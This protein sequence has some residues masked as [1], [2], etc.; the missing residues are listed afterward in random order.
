MCNDVGECEG[1]TVGVIGEPPAGEALC[2]NAPL[3]PRYRTRR[4][5]KLSAHLHRNKNMQGAY[6]TQQN[7]MEAYKS[8]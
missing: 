5:N 6:T 3:P 1:S 8:V 4:G 7:G 2:G